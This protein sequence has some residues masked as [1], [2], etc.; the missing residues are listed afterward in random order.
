M[1]ILTNTIG[2]TNI[3]TYTT[4]ADANVFT[5][6]E[7]YPATNYSNVNTSTPIEAY[8]TTDYNIIE[9]SQT[10]FPNTK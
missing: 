10:R 9:D 2:T 1:Q 5:T 7:A 6:A 3:D 8:Q 4:S